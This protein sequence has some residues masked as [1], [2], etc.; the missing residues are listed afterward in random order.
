MLIGFILEMTEAG[1]QV[2]SWVNGPP[3]TTT[4][5]FGV[6]IKDKEQYPVQ[7]FRCSKCG[8]LES[9]ARQA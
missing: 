5:S 9:Y 6:K 1:R 3:E 2:S 8:Y 4:W 7:S